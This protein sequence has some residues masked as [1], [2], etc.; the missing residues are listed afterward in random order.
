MRKFWWELIFALASLTAA[1]IAL[2]TEGITP[3]DGVWWIVLAGIAAGDSLLECFL[4]D[5]KEW[6]KRP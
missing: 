4:D 6:R 3:A 2:Q 1:L 5:F